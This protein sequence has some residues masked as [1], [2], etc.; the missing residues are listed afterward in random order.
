MTP[1]K[2]PDPEQ[3]LQSLKDFQR[4][5]VEY[6][7]RRMYTD[8]PSTRRF[9]VADEV[10]LGKTLV[11]R[12]LI[13]RAVDH[14]WD[15]VPR[16]DVVYICSNADIAQQNL[17]RL[18]LPGWQDF[19]LASRIT[20][21]PLKMKELRRTRGVNFVSFTPGTSFDMKSSL[22]TGE[23]RALLFHLLRKAWS[24]NGEGPKHALEGWKGRANFEWQ[25][26]NFP[27]QSIDRGLRDRFIERANQ[28]PGLRERFAEI[29]QRFSRVRSARRVDD[30]RIRARNRIVGEL[31]LLLA[32]TCLA[33]LEPDLV[34]LDEFQ[35]FKY[36]L[37]TDSEAGQ[38]A[39][40]LFNY[41][42]THSQARVVLLSA[43]PY[44]MYTL[45]EEAAGEDHYQDFVQTVGFLLGDD[46]AR[47][48]DFRQLLNC[49]RRELLRLAD[50]NLE[51]VCELKGAIEAVLR[52]VMVRTERLAASADRDGMLRVVA[53][54]HVQLTAGDISSFLTVQQ[55]ARALG[56]PDVLE[57]WK[58]APYLLN[59]MEEYKLKREFDQ[60]HQ[61]PERRHAVEQVLRSKDGLLPRAD[62]EAYRAI[63]PGNARLRNL[64]ADTVEAG[65]WRWL[66]IAPALPYYALGGPYAGPEARAFTKR[67][68]FSSW[69]VAPKAIATLTSYEVE[70]RMMTSFE[71][72]AENTPEARRKR[73]PLLRLARDPKGEPAGM[74]VLGLL[75]PSQTLAELA[76][77]LKYTLSQG[78]SETCAAIGEVLA[79]ARAKIERCL[80]A[81]RLPDP[82]TGDE[83]Q[84]WYW[85][86][87]ILLDRQRFTESTKGWWEQVDLPLKWAA[88]IQDPDTADEDSNWAAH[89]QEAQALLADRAEPLGRRPADLTTVLAELA[90]AGPGVAA[91][92]ALARV[93]GTTLPRV[94][95]SM[96]NG[97]AQIGWGFRSLFN[98]PEAT[99]L[100]RGLSFDELGDAPVKQSRRSLPSILR[101]REDEVPYWRKALEYCLVGCIQAVLDEYVHVL[102]E[103]LGL[104]AADQDKTV[105][106][107]AEAVSEALT[108]RTSALRVDD[109]RLDRLRQSLEVSRDWAIRAHF[110]VRFGDETSDDGRQ[111]TRKEQVLR[112]F[113]SPFWPFVL[114]TTAVGQE[115]L[116]FHCYSHAV[117]HWNLPAN[118]VDLEQREGRVHRYKGHAVRKNVALRYRDLS[119]V[120]SAQRDP[121]QDLF[122]QA[123]QDS[124][125]TTELVPYWIFLPDDKEQGAYIERHIPAL[126][127]SR[128]LI[129]AAALRRSL[130]V[131]RM[132][133]GQARQEDL[134]AY[135]L[136]HLPESECG[137]VA[138]RLQINLEPPH[139]G[140]A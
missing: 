84:R 3:V 53:P 74:T 108:L 6:V 65:A 140:R 127:L 40:Q 7:F 50:G 135:L 94:D 101:P 58:S 119:P 59:F 98:S 18:R 42:D 45:P 104:Q 97:A 114:A 115:G 56:Q 112:A 123:K 64:L 27:T 28:T 24:L 76:D 32:Q 134:V 73:R 34:F 120:K 22:G 8:E 52:Q 4:D 15:A 77:P 116:D 86:A 38:L 71:P 48:A 129:R 23:E 55:V 29:C 82:K 5:T 80:A 11:A 51:R 106:E 128:D 100:V 91:L 110:A 136:A 68:I 12:G 99:A 102:R 35:R 60:A 62:F 16:I 19:S 36:L 95:N 83:D 131:Y 138:R 10:G 109:V 9:L 75:Y 69:R 132:A 30:E 93:C 47:I 133:F 113:N 90:L 117:M 26:D 13:A 78:R 31:R 39:L 118:P 85:A 25:L 66:W 103:S 44:K 33:E 20:L 122:E 1:K 17:N 41:A 126:P 37:G 121:W 57:Y 125:Q 54:Y 137:H 21:L 70:R 2:R 124:G 61:S 63:D 96:R 72:D 111:V 46:A 139:N 43:T 130:A 88:G 67:L 107:I 105:T 89:I 79:W 81:A 49:Y 87:P 14:L 92:R